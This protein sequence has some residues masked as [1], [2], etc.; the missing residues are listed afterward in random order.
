M[1]A[2]FNI[3]LPPNPLPE[4][5]LPSVFLAGSIEQGQ[6]SN[7]QLQLINYLSKSIDTINIFNPRR[8]DWDSTWVQSIDNQQFREQV[9]WELDGMDLAD[10]ICLYFDP[11]TSAPISLLEL[12]LHAGHKLI[13]CCPKGYWRK[14]NVDIVCARYNVPTVDTLL[15]LAEAVTIRLKRI[16]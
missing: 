5:G 6:A 3:Y 2:S 8:K 13:V 9:E 14:G 16:V 12:G 11:A 1:L 10:V 7:W 15:E 4:N